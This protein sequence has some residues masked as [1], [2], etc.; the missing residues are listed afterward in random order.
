MLIQVK[1]LV[2]SD[3]GTMQRGELS[4]AMPPMNYL[5]GVGEATQSM[6]DALVSAIKY[7]AKPVTDDLPFEEEG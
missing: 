4:F 2:Q 5:Q 7:P 6:A 3:E 1:I